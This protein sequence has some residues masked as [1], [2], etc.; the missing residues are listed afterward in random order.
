MKITDQINGWARQKLAG[1]LFRAS[2]ENPS[3]SLSNP[4]SWLFDLFGGQK[5]A[6]GI[7][8]NEETALTVGAVY[9]AVR[10]ISNSIG[11]LPLHVYRRDDS[12]K[13]SFAVRHWAYPLL[14][15]SP[16]E[17]HTSTIWLRMMMAH[18]LLWGNSYNRIE[19]VGN[20][21][22]R[23]LLPLMPWC[24]TP[25]RTP[26]GMQVYDVRLSDGSMETLP[27]DE[28]LHIPGLMYDGIQ[29]ISVI[30]AMRDSA[31]L[32]KVAE[33]F[34]SSFFANGA[35]PGIVLEVP[36]KMKEGAQQTLAKSVMA[37][38]SGPSNAFKAMVLEEGAKL[39]NVQM[40]MQDA[41][42]LETRRFQRS[43]ILGW[44]GIPP[45]LGGDTERSTSWG[46]GIEQQDIGFAKHTIA[47][48][49]VAVEQELN[50]K[51]FG[52]GTGLYAKFN[53]DGLMRG[54]F[55]SRM[56]GYR[57]AVGA[58]FL[59]RNEA[60]ELEDWNTMSD[61]GMDEVI[62]PLNMGVG[63]KPDVPDASGV[64]DNGNDNDVDNARAER[65]ATLQAITRIAELSAQ[66]AAAP[67]I[68]VNTP[69]VRVD[70][71]VAP[72][73]TPAVHVTNQIPA[74]DTP[75][76]K[77]E[78]DARSTVQVPEQSRPIIEVKND[79]TVEQK[80]IDVNVHLPDRRTQSEV[81]RD[82]KGLITKVTQ[83]E[84]DA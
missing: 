11:A 37:G 15:D 84:T 69:A 10:I 77:V 8:M 21:S 59:S 18:L 44:Y 55:K 41:Q 74:Q 79:V 32:A 53:L 28:V 81:L 23:N 83:T 20:G 76:I 1:W 57:I 2:P 49:C 63:A 33:Q 73:A 42:F 19:W 43:E 4:D 9:T 39:H 13:R 40:P 71:H 3:T 36:G 29:G 50:R 54:D 56:E 66:P 80:P 5:T 45:H 17:Y 64:A 70:N 6:A 51:L 67:V 72:A 48:W 46:T 16:N 26:T 58:P 47:P 78:V 31:A 82:S 7:R 62:T 30:G 75:N 22:A 34:G 60:R 68:T 65:T 52:R 24:V 12:G 14:H 27:G 35:R 25:R 61:A 38:F